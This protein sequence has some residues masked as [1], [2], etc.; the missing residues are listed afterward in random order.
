MCPEPSQPGVGHLQVEMQIQLTLGNK[1]PG[2]LTS[3]LAEGKPFI[4]QPHC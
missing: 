2:Y 1:I 3:L 4:A